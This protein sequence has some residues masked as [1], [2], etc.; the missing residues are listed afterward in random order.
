MARPVTARTFVFHWYVL[1]E[2]LDF[3]FRVMKWKGYKL[4]EPPINARSNFLRD[5]EVPDES[6][7]SE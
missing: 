7:I 4:T 3:K 5:M 6:E 2:L 1:I